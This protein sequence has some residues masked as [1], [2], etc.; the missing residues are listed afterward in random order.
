MHVTVLTIL[1][2]SFVVTVVAALASA[3]LWWDRVDFPSA[4]ASVR[5]GLEAYI[6]AWL[7]RS[8]HSPT[9]SDLEA[10]LF[11]SRRF[12]LYLLVGPRLDSLFDHRARHDITTSLPWPQVKFMRAS[13]QLFSSPRSSPRIAIP[14]KYSIIYILGC[15]SESR[16]LYLI[17][18]LE[19]CHLGAWDIWDIFT[20]AERDNSGFTTSVVLPPASFRSLQERLKGDFIHSPLWIQTLRIQ[21]VPISTS[22]VFFF[23]TFANLL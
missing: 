23:F 15:I 17:M 3:V 8:Q 21:Y 12:N 7:G 22:F 2:V 6:E 14:Q 20:Q 10:A 16:H 1:R 13:I 11:I 5:F 18:A 4:R 9:W 19:R